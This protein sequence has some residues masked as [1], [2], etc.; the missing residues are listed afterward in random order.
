ME[1]LDYVDGVLEKVISDFGFEVCGQNIEK[2][3]NLVLFR[4]VN[5]VCLALLEEVDHLGS[6]LVVQTLLV[7][8]VLQ[9][10]ISRLLFRFRVVDYGENASQA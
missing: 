5:D 9:Y 6:E 7:Y 10:L 4:H 3:V 1:D 8:K 2:L